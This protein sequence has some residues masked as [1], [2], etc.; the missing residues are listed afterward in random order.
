MEDDARDIMPVIV[1]GRYHP[2]VSVPGPVAALAT[3]HGPMRVNSWLCATAPG[4]ALL[5][6]T[7]CDFAALEAALAR[8]ALQPAAL[9][10]THDHPDHIAALGEIRRTWPG[11]PVHAPRLD[12]V[13]GADLFTAPCTLATAGT[14]VRCLALPGHTDG[15]AGYLVE[16]PGQPPLLF[17]GDALFAG[18]IGGPRFSFEAARRSLGRLVDCLCP[19]TVVCPGHGPPTTIALETRHNPFLSGWSFS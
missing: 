13:P 7:G 16:L 17:C 3:W 8:R 18:S 1:H 9:L 6:D 10:L 15:S 19:Q 5:I 12:P 4:Q 14:A 11:L 2:D